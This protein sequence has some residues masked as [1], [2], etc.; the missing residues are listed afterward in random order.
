[1]HDCLTIRRTGQ[2]S[3]VFGSSFLRVYYGASEQ[4][5]LRKRQ[6]DIL[7]GHILIE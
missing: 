7:A 3:D 6:N 5:N 4:Q 1:M 2:D